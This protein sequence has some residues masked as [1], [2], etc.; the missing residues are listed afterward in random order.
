[1]KKNYIIMVGVIYKGSGFMGLLNYLLDTG[2]RNGKILSVLAFAGVNVPFDEEGRDVYDPSLIA[3]SF[4]LQA[5]LRPGISKPVRHLVLSGVEADR[6]KLSPELWRAIARDY[7]MEMGI[8]DTQYF[9]VEHKEKNNPH[10]HI[11]Y[12]AVDNY[13]AALKDGNF[14]R[15]NV[16][17][18][19]S[20]TKQYKLGWGR[21]KAVSVSDVHN[22]KEQ[23][24][25]S[26]AR[27]VTGALYYAN[28]LSDL[29]NILKR[30]GIGMRVKSYPQDG[31]KGI[32]FE[33][34]GVNGELV[35]FSGIS[36]GRHLSYH[37]IKNILSN[38]YKFHEALKWARR[39][40][41]SDYEM[42][43]IDPQAHQYIN[44][45]Q[46]IL[47]LVDSR[48][49]WIAQL[50]PKEAKALATVLNIAGHAKDLL[51]LANIMA[52]P[53]DRYRVQTAS[54]PRRKMTAEDLQQ[55]RDEE[56]A[57]GTNVS[58]EDVRF[59]SNIH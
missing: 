22:P 45:L 9:I 25:Y 50:R 15:K 32:V 21:I 48:Q 51:N 52:R 26:L 2:S 31:R 30:K 7:M 3:S 55:R 4:R 23:V 8:K 42:A 54:P 29:Q 19:R 47:L 10:I 34:N 18:C 49:A 14:K 35:C 36:L 41:A 20:L 28:S 16:E 56:A 38:K 12:N 17:V 57:G 44:R 58:F 5:G 13:G 27:E 40:M 53:E 11:V 59:T 33:T 39:V 1:M 46:D 43:R 37:C 24:R 6:K